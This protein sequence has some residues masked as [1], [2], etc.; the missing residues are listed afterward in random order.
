MIA[1][2][3]FI[4]K[5]SYYVQVLSR[6]EVCVWKNYGLF[7]DERYQSSKALFVLRFKLVESFLIYKI[8]PKSGQLFG[9]CMKRCQ[10]DLI[11]AILVDIALVVCN[12]WNIKPIKG[13]TTGIFET[14]L[15][16]RCPPYSYFMHQIT[17]LYLNYGLDIV[18]FS[19]SI[20]GIK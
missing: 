6:K 14:F 19:F 3:S 17:V 5:N 1:I 18:L 9:H 11:P 12:I 13:G 20:N 7:L 8:L 15:S 10:K 16:P 4:F 2:I